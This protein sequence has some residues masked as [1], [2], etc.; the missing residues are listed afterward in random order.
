MYA[1]GIGESLNRD[2]F[3]SNFNKLFILSLLLGSVI[4]IKAGEIGT[5]GK[6][7]V[8]QMFRRQSLFGKLRLAAALVTLDHRFLPADLDPQDQN[9]RSSSVTLE[10]PVSPT[11]PTFLSHSSVVSPDPA[12]SLPVVVA[13][14]GKMFDRKSL[15]GKLKLVA[16]LVTLDHRFLPVDLDPQGQNSRSSSFLSHSLVV[17]PDS[18][19]SVPV[20]VAAPE[21]VVVPVRSFRSL[22]PERRS[23]K[24]NALSMQARGMAREATGIAQVANLKKNTKGIHILPVIKE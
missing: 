12:I 7:D 22:L 19:I 2:I 11:S 10:E 8:W 1:L 13:A 15:F 20:V 5:P 3:V 14:P 21:P 4:G 23:N 9:S 24:E 6:E 18:A 17:S 16:A